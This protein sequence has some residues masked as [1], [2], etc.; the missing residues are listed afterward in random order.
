MVQIGLKIKEV[1]LKRNVPDLEFD[2]SQDGNYLKNCVS[3]KYGGLQPS[4]F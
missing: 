4:I 3:R 2:L 1:I